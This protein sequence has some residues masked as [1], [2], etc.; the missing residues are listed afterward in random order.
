MD[1]QEIVLKSIKKGVVINGNLFAS[2]DFIE[3]NSAIVIF[4]GSVALKILKEGRRGVDCSTASVR[5]S[6]LIEE[7]ETNSEINASLYFGVKPVFVLDGQIVITEDNLISTE[8]ADYVL[9]MK[10]LKQSSLLYNVLLSG[11]YCDEFSV[12]VAK[13][14]ASFHQCKMSGKLTANDRGLVEK[15]GTVDSLLDIVERDFQMFEELSDN[16]IPMAVTR[17]N[18]QKIKKYL[19]GFL[20]N[21]MALLTERIKSG[22]V[23]PIHG[24]FHSRN[25]FVENGVVYVIDRSLRRNMR[26]SDIVKDVAYFAVDLEMFG[27]ERQKRIFLNTY[28][29]VI[30]DEY[31]MQLLPFYMCRRALVAAMSN[32]FEESV[33]HL[34]VYF[35]I[36]CK[37]AKSSSS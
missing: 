15:F 25:I 21:R 33:E 7:M 17:Q 26:V 36:A 11:S 32:L 34:K 35:D 37:Y 18:Y 29:S 14:I 23:L 30:E 5:Q 3:T 13:I 12:L 24:D 27:L 10:R 16:F 28:R 2:P 1:N 9:D 20:K 6:L 4:A 19:A 31:F 22:Y 8:V